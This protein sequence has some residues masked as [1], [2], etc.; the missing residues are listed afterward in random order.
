MFIKDERLSHSS[1]FVT[2]QLNNDSWNNADGNHQSYTNSSASIEPDILKHLR[3]P[4]LATILVFYEFT[5]SMYKTTYQ[6][7]PMKPQVCLTKVIK[8]PTLAASRR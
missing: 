1:P 3:E 8:T 7:G 4:I 2:L 6:N 5:Q